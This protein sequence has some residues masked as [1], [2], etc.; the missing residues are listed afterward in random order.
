[1]GGEDA[2]DVLAGGFNPFEKNSSRWESS[3][4]LGENKNIFETTTQFLNGWND[5]P[6]LNFRHG[7][8][9]CMGM[10]VFFLGHFVGEGMKIKD[11]GK[12]FVSI[13][14]GWIHQ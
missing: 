6:A 10:K 7:S 2:A 5:S 12:Q 4:I 13:V 1:M 8:F 3:Q 9:F 14:M 11:V